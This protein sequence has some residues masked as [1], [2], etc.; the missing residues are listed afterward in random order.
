MMLSDVDTLQKFRFLFFISLRDSREETYVSHMIKTQ[1]IYKIYPEDKWESAYKRVLR[2]M[3]NVMYLIIPDGLD[4]WP[5]KE[6]LPSMDE[7]PKEQCT[8]LTTY[9]PWELAD[10]RI[11][12]SQIDILFDLEGIRDPREFNK[13]I[14][15]C[16]LDKSKD[17]KK[18]REAV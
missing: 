3:K 13:K 9:R 8:V 7:I 5:C 12:N 10:E 15:R 6:T 17:I 16:L 2:I 14:L 18:K 4:E 11:R 1:L